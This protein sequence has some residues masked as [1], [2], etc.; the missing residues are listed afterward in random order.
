MR[1]PRGTGSPSAGAGAKSVARGVGVGVCGTPLQ[2]GSPRRPGE[3]GLE[4]FWAHMEFGSQ[5][6]RISVHGLDATQVLKI[7]H[8]T[9]KMGSRQI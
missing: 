8:K 9:H 1:I 3:P 7:P 4:T 5:F 2:R 6:E